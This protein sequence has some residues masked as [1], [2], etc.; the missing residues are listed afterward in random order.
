MQIE[1]E[2]LKYELALTED[3]PRWAE[4]VLMIADHPQ[5]TG[6]L[7]GFL[8]WWELDPHCDEEA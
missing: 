1:L 4:L 3:R 6:E 2:D 7:L 8:L 5:W